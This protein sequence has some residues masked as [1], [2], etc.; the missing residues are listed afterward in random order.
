MEQ[1]RLSKF[2]D[3]PI[4]IT[5][6]VLFDCNF[7]LIPV[8]NSITKFFLGE[9]E[10]FSHW[11]ISEITK[12]QELFCKYVTWEET[13]KNINLFDISENLTD[14]ISV[15]YEF[16]EFNFGF[17]SQSRKIRARINGQLSEKKETDNP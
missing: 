6:M 12:L 13:G 4:K 14:F 8:M 7:I 10:L 9:S 3:K 1:E 16:L 11:K 15:Q 5:K 17:F 2:N